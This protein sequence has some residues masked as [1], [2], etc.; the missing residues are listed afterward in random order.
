MVAAMP[1]TDPVC[2][3]PDDDKFLACA[4]ASKAKVIC[5]GD[6]A[7]LKTTGYR[8]IEVMTPRSFA[9]RFLGK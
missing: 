2:T 8:G 4:V 7:L 6:K 3:D 5:S 9:D 1:L